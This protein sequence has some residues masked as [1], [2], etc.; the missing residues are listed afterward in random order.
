MAI[1]KKH[2]S[3]FTRNWSSGI[4]DIQFV[5]KEGTYMQNAIYATFC[6]VEIREGKVSK[7]EKASPYTKKI[8][9]CWQYFKRKKRTIKKTP[10]KKKTVKKKPVK[11]KVTKKKS[12]KRTSTKKKK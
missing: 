3:Q 12:V 8:Y 9:P 5:Q 2:I 1:L 7:L 11:K 10:V 6:R 4:Y